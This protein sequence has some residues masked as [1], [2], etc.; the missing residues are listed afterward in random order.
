MVSMSHLHSQAPETLTA[1]LREQVQALLPQLQCRKCGYIDCAAYATALADGRAPINRCSPGGDWT[2]TRLA[3]LLDQPVTAIDT[4]CP[5]HRAGRVIIDE[6]EC[7]GCARC[8]PACPVRAIIGMPRLLHEVLTEDCTGCELCIFTCPVD[9]IHWM[10]T[11]PSAQPWRGWTLPQAAH[12][13]EQYRRCNPRTPEVTPRET[14]HLRRQREIQEAVDRVRRRR[15][16]M[17]VD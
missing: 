1:A 15:G 9:C 5:T 17:P 11:E 3:A 7:I 16:R 8:L 13:R 10:P 12:A 6:T 14:D 4:A 2:V